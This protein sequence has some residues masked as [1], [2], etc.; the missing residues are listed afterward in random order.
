M[1]LTLRATVIFPHLCLGFQGHVQAPVFP[2]PPSLCPREPS[3]GRGSGPTS[4]P[5]AALN[6]WWSPLREPPKSIVSPPSSRRRTL[7]LHGKDGRFTGGQYRV[8]PRSAHSWECAK[9]G[10]LLCCYLLVSALFSV[11]TAAIPFRLENED[12]SNRLHV[13]RAVLGP[14]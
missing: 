8:G 11:R 3:F 7:A 4:C 2:G 9:Q 13:F 1:A 10:L 14:Q 12:G 5:P 6:A